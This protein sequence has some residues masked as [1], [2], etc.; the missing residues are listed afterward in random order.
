MIFPHHFLGLLPFTNILLSLMY[1][2]LGKCIYT[3]VCIYGFL[4]VTWTETFAFV[5]L[6]RL[7]IKGL[8]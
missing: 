8:Y 4:T 5:A 7:K 3:Y 1:K 6:Q 2:L